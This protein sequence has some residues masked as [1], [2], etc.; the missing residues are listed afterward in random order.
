MQR[1]YG[2]RGVGRDVACS[3]PTGEVKTTII[4]VKLAQKT[5]KSN[6]LSL[7]T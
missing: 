2:S 6:Y 1:P 4:N 5:Q 3:R 7:I